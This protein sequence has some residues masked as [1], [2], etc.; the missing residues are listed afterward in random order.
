MNQLCLYKV[1]PGVALFNVHDGMEAMLNKFTLV[2]YDGTK[3]KM[4]ILKE[5]DY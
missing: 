3:Y 2:E 1:G 4:E 5:K